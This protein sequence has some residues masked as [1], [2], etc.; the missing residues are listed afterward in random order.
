MAKTKV[1]GTDG[2]IDRLIKRM[3]WKYTTNVADNERKDALAALNEAEQWIAQRE[4]FLHLDS[5][6]TV[7]LGAAGASVAVPSGI[8]M[9]K[10]ITLESP[11]GGI[12]EYA[13]PDE[14]ISVA[15]PTHDA[16]GSTP[17]YYTIRYD[18][19]ASAFKFYFKPAAG[20][21]G[22][23]IPISFQRVPVAL[24]DNGSSE[25]TLPEGYELTLLLPRAEAELK[26]QMSK[27]GWQELSAEVKEDL[28]RF[29]AQYRKSKE[30][31]TSDEGQARRKTMRAQMAEG[32]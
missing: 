32:T 26:R 1:G 21:A 6:T 2:L 10:D 27:P 4:S 7:S 16:I 12:I 13:P 24:V 9:G 22:A 11:A 23:T 29:F 15:A 25:S 8:D 17:S 5:Y 20:G 31:A 14:F 18:T 30:K 19:G 28:E 3:G